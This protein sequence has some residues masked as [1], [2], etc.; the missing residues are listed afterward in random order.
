M[1]FIVSFSKLAEI[2][3]QILTKGTKVF[4]S[5]RLQSR[6]I[7][8]L[9][10]QEIKKVEIVAN[11]VIGLDKRKINQGTIFSQEEA[12]SGNEKKFKKKLLLFLIFL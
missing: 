1:H 12:S 11:Q 5:G 6:K 10:G 4:I 7:T 3:S 9:Q 8:N 2:C